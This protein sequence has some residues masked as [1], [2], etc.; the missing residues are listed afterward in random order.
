MSK[1]IK[2]FY[3]LSGLVFCLAFA[4]YPMFFSRFLKV[5]GDIGDERFGVFVLNHWF[6]VLRFKEPFFRLNFF[7]PVKDAMGFSDGFF[8]L[9]VVYSVF[10]FFGL[11]YFTSLQMLYIFMTSLGYLAG[12]LVL[13][14]ILKLNYFFGIFGAVL[15]VSLNAIQNQFGHIQLLS[16]YFYPALALLIYYYFDSKKAG[17]SKI[18]W[19]YM[20]SFAVLLGLLCFTSY[21]AFW[22]FVFSVLIFIF[23]YFANEFIYSYAAS[24][25]EGRSKISWLYMISF[26][27]L[28][29]L[30]FFTSDYTLWFFGFISYVFIFFYLPEKIAGRYFRDRLSGWLVFIKTN[31][32]QLSAGFFIFIASLAPAFIVYIPVIF[33]GFRFPFFLNFSPALKDIIN[34]GPRNYL[35]SGVLNIFHFDYGSGEI[36]NGL[37]VIT[38]LVLIFLF[39]FNR[40]ILKGREKEKRIL[41]PFAVTGVFI[42]LLIFNYRGWYSMWYFVYIFVPGAVGIRALGRFFIVSQMIFAVFISYNLNYLFAGAKGKIYH[43]FSRGIILLIFFL[44]LT[45]QFNAGYFFLNKKRQ[46][47]FITRFN[48]KTGCGSFF[49]KYNTSYKK[50]SWVYGTDALMISMK[51]KIPTINGYSGFYP[52]KWHLKYPSSKLYNYYVSRW[53]KE[54]RLRNVCSVNL[55]TGIF[56]HA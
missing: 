49:I 7:Y 50:P 37:P 28:L 39:I 23:F 38:L 10:R 47:A 4:Y 51:T 30:L 13:R 12:F 42:F 11:D 32:V 53:I 44:V 56:K 5:P 6:N 41:L 19:L 24:K 52:R 40:Q 15:L 27:V 20:I 43:S 36:Q 17:R 3:I 21:Y 25:N 1:K 33:S 26:A 45:E 16:F 54:N 2:S 34:V 31:K 35:W 22:F 55:K 18:S 29:A 46:L 14:K 9:G 8:L 48:G